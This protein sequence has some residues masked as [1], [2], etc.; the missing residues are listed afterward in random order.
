MATPLT[1]RQRFSLARF[2]RGLGTETGPVTLDRRR[3]YILPTRQGLLLGAVLLAILLGAINYDNGLAFALVFLLT[4]LGVVSI[5]HTWRNLLGLRLEAGRC[6][7]VFAGETAR[8]PVGVHNDGGEVRPAVILQAA[9]GSE[10]MADMGPGTQWVELARP[11]PRRGRLPLGRITVATRFPLGLFR[12]WSPL[13]L[14][15]DCLVYPAP[16][17]QRG[18]PPDQPGTAGS[19]GERGQGHDDFAALRP[20][21]AGDSLRHVHWKAVAREQ[22]MHTKQFAGEAAQELWLAW[23]LLPG[24]AP[25]ARLSRLCRWVLEADAAGL[26]Y[27]LRLPDRTIAPDFGPAQ[28]RRCLEALALYGERP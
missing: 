25:E 7:A 8:F 9:H 5:L 14:A 24:V 28:R 11:A 19:G 4:G 10:A 23:E 21:H 16:A 6:P 27:G 15:M 1:L 18:L 2:L 20:Y 26:A 17:P 13:E 22:G 12:A 3:I